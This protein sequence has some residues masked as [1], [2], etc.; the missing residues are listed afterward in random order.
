MRWPS[1]PQKSRYILPGLL[2]LEFGCL[3]ALFGLFGYANPNTYRSALLD[4]GVASGFVAKSTYTPGSTDVPLVWRPVATTVSLYLTLASFLCMVLQATL[5]ILSLCPP[6]ALALVQ[7][8]MLSIWIAIIAI[9]Q[10]GVNSETPWFLTHSCA[11]VYYPRNR[12]PCLQ[13]K[14]LFGISIVL[15]AIYVAVG[16]WCV[17]VTVMGVRLRLKSEGRESEAG[18]DVELVQ[19]RSAEE[20][21]VDYAYQQPQT[22]GRVPVTPY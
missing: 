9:Y 1:A 7:V 21:V 13:A 5:Y 8:I 17:V 6:Q 10:A 11:D 18:K 12:S 2:I 22:P 19:G 3:T 15:V 4:D 20:P 16:V 14:G